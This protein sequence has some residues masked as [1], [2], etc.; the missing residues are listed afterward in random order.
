[1]EV[2]DVI[3]ALS[4]L[5]R[6]TAVASHCVLN[7]SW[8]YTPWPYRYVVKPIQELWRFKYGLRITTVGERS[9]YKRVS[10]S[11]HKSLSFHLQFTI[12]CPPSHNE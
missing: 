7:T 5:F 8:V 3:T 11:S 6:V 9:I 10:Q 2:N 1:M 12:I 4:R